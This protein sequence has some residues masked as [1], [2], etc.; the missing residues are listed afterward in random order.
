MMQTLPL[1]I[2]FA[3]LHGHV[4][5]FDAISF[6]DFY[7]YLKNMRDLDLMNAYAKSFTFCF[8]NLSPFLWLGMDSVYLWNTP[9]PCEPDW[10]VFL[11]LYPLGHCG[12]YFPAIGHILSHAFGSQSLWSLLQDLLRENIPALWIINA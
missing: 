2:Y 9:I 10:T 6:K 5:G 8:I 7:L 11:W 1:S 4:K 3:M 12:Q